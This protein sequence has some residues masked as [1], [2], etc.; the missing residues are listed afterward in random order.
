MRYKHDSSRGYFIYL[1][2]LSD[3]LYFR[4]SSHISIA[5]E[6]PQITEHFLLIHSCFRSMTEQS[7]KS[8]S[9]VMA[10]RCQSTPRD[11]R[12]ASQRAAMGEIQKKMSSIRHLHLT[13]MRWNF[14][15]DEIRTALYLQC[16]ERVPKGMTIFDEHKTS[17]D[18]FLSDS[19]ETSSSGRVPVSTRTDDFLETQD[20]RTRS[21]SQ[22]VPSLRFAA[23]QFISLS[24]PSSTP[25]RERMVRE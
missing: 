19:D 15:N 17:L 4:H 7:N 25:A 2:T 5:D 11:I 13:E 10:L 9:W 22:V 23:K 24:C 20:S 1:S 12:K 6:T 14:P 18:M 21:K 16:R 8:E 3:S